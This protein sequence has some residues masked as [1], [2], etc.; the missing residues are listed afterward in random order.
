MR[1]A[2]CKRSVAWVIALACL[3]FVARG[4]AVVWF[5]HNYFAQSVYKLL[6]VGIP[7]GW[8]RGIDG[9]RGAQAVWP[10]DEPL[11]SLRTCLLAVAIAAVSVTM[12]AL[13]LPSLAAW[14]GIE[15]ANVRAHF[16]RT[17]DLTPSLAVGISIFLTLVNSGIEELHY[18][19]WLDRE[20]SNRFGRMIG[21]GASAAAFAGMHTFIFAG[22]KEFTAGALALM[23]VALAAMGT[24]WSLLARRRGGI[25]AAWLS[26]ALTD[27][28]FLTWGLYWLGYF[29][30]IGA[31]G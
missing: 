25:H 7:L 9:K 29:Q 16:D 2:E 4:T 15:A 8:R 22:L 19:A 28:G 27:A 10:I 31:M 17:F 24:L 20:L 6:Q 18:R 5:A 30:A 13:I 3:P 14:M 1:N 26:H 11:P 12:A 23:F 21:I